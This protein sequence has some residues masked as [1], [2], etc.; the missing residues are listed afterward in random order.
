M[1]DLFQLDKNRL[2]QEWVQQIPLFAEWADKLAEARQTERRAKAQLELT[3]AEVKLSI[4]RNP[5]QYGFE[6][7]TEG[8]AAE[9][10]TVDK[11]YQK[12]LAD[13]HAAEHTVDVYK[14]KV[15]TLHQRKGGLE[16]L[17]R[18][19]L[20]DYFSEPKAPPGT[21]E[22]MDGVRAD[23]NHKRLARAGGKAK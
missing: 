1:P 4:R 13:H 23:H 7:V 3:E 2:D 6:K 18:L 9:L 5:Q 11:R 14:A 17:V 21:R 19:R 10:L 15:D 16:D 20:A 12:A 8:T 22:V